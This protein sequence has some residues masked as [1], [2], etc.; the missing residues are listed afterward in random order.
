MKYLPGTVGVNRSPVKLLLVSKASVPHVNLVFTPD[1][2]VCAVLA[3]LTENAIGWVALGPMLSH[4][5]PL[6]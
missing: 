2:M 3:L 6:Q 4:A 1:E 5:L